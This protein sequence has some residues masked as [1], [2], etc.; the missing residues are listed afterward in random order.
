MI[1]KVLIL[2]FWYNYNILN[3]TK[4]LLLANDIEMTERNDNDNTEEVMTIV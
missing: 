4:P 1:L 2:L 3:D